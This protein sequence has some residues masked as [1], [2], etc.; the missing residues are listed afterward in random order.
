MLKFHFG[1]IVN[2]VLDKASNAVEQAPDDVREGIIE[3]VAGT[4]HVLHQ[5]QLQSLREQFGREYEAALEQNLDNDQA[6]ADAAARITQGSR[7]ADS[8]RRQHSK[9]I[10]CPS[11]HYSKRSN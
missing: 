6:Q 5:D 9:I 7:P 3:K 11:F 4:L 10:I 1:L 2:S 8:K